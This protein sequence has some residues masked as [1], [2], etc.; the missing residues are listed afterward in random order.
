M[1]ILTRLYFFSR[2]SEFQNYMTTYYINTLSRASPFFVG[3]IYG[4]LLHICRDKRIK[5]SFVSIEH[6][7]KIIIEPQILNATPVTL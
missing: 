7:V 2:M 6:T 3:M 5:I 4:Y 1:H